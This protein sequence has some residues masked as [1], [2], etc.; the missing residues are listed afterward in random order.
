[1]NG[2]HVEGVAQD[3]GNPLVGA[4]VGE[5]IPREDAFDTDDKIFPIG[6]N[7]LEKRLWACLYIPMDQYLSIL[8]QDA[9][10]HGTG[11]QI[12]ATVK[13]VLFGVKSH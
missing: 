2:L 8:V 6:G 1:M 4:E 11:M 10:V 13:L 9:D 5:P 3:E 12:D 7:R